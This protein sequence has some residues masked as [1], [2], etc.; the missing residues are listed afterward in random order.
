MIH[1]EIFLNDIWSVYFHNPIS[2]NWERDG[3][4]KI[5]DISTVNDFWKTY[6]EIKKHIHSGMFFIMREHI[7]PKW[8]DVENKDGSFLSFK[9]L[10]THIED[11]SE[12]IMIQMLGE[13]L[14]TDD[15]RNKWN[16]VN[17][18]SFSPKKNFCI[19]KIWL[20]SK[21]LKAKDMFSIPD[22]YQG[23]IFFK[24]NNM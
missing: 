19:V 7:F 12:K 2:N 14:L 16:H 15:N 11:F 21:D 20:K 13:T 10:K 6:N 3:Y 4:V 5:N 23:D 18:I 24:D 22:M 9:V 8:D 17:G 1:K